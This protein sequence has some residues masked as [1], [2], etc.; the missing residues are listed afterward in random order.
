MNKVNLLND[1]SEDALIENRSQYEYQNS[2]KSGQNT[3]FN[4]NSQ[5]A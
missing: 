3:I 5:F 4:Q 1:K 2:L